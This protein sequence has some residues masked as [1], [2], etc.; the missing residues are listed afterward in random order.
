MVDEDDT[1]TAILMRF[2]AWYIKYEKCKELKK[3]ISNEFRKK[4]K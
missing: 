2:L 4:G 1:D 3:N